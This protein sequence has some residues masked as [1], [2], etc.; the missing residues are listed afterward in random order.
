MLD[1]A[2]KSVYVKS[3][4]ICQRALEFGNNLLNETNGF[5]L[6]IDNEEDLAGL[7]DGGLPLQLMQ[8]KL[9]EKKINGCLVYKSL[10]GYLFFSILKKRSQRKLYKAMYMRGDNDNEN[11][12]KDIINDIVNLR[13]ESTNVGVQHPC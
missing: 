9:K 3:T 10:V 5:K 1:D 11:D 13:V 8:Q 7:P 12:N 4:K 6:V 2:Q